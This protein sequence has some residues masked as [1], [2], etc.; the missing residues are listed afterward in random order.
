MTTSAAIHQDSS[1]ARAAPSGYAPKL[2]R[3][4]ASAVFTVLVVAA[5]IVGWLQRDEGHLTPE[6]GLGYWLGIG[7]GVA[8]LLLLLYP[9][10]KRIQFLR[11][12]GS[13]PNWF[14]IH[15]ILGI[16]GPVLIL[17]HA[18]FKLGSANSNVALFSMLLVAGSGIAG[19]YIYGKIHLGLYGRRANVADI[20]ADA[21]EYKVDLADD[22]PLANHIVQA[23]NAFSA[24]AL[25]P[26]AG[27]ISG[28]VRLMTLGT[29]ARRSRRQLLNDARA[30]IAVQADV[31]GWSRRVQRQHVKAVRDHLNLFFVAVRKAA[32]FVFYERLFS[33]WHVLHL[34]LFFLLILTAI[35]HVI[36]VHTF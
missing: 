24:D 2:S 33:L 27:L 3:H 34:P 16:I 31:S 17:F 28:A 19:R 1:H 4:V 14:R 6:R 20:I 25:K 32:A 7:G 12:F 15:M 36:A 5:L 26:S 23:L 11:I 21:N 9:L 22:L 29:K 35:L 13:V 18:N 30:V 8:M 10:R